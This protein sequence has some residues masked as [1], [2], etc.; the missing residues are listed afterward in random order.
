MKFQKKIG[1][2][3]E[4]QQK[5]HFMRYVLEKKKKNFNTREYDLADIIH[6]DKPRLENKS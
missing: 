2:I 4:C 3:I 1:A 5:L 6:S